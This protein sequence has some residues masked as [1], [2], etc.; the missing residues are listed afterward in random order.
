[1]QTAKREKS[2]IKE[3]E[4]VELNL[5]RGTVKTSQIDWGETSNSNN[6][7]ERS[8]GSTG[9]SALYSANILKNNHQATAHF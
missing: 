5:V 6:S 7:S 1:M 2:E 8:G 3:R 9:S 4:S